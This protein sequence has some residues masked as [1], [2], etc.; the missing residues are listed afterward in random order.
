M[1]II[2]PSGGGGG[3]ALSQ[4]FNSLLVGSAAS[5]DIQ[6]IPASFNHLLIIGY[7]RSDTA[8]AITGCVARFNNDSAANYD[9]D[10]LS[11]SAGT[12][13]AAESLGGTSITLAVVPANTATANYFGAV[14]ATLPSY[15]N[16]TGNKPIVSPFHQSDSNVTGHV[17]PG[18]GGGKWRTAGTPITRVTILPGAG[19]WVAGSQLSVYGLT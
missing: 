9:E 3:G 2:S 14:S 8:A 4:I 1:P 7:L 19:N 18:V 12:P 17:Q 13:S 5:F 11:A 16:A 15:L 6:N 10:R